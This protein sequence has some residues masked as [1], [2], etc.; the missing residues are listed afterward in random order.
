MARKIVDE[1]KVDILV[2][3]FLVNPSIKDISKQTGMSESTIYRL[4]ETDDF[5]T[6]LRDARKRSL[7][8]A[9]TYLQES[10]LGC[11]KVLVEIANN[12]KVAVGCRVNAAQAVIAQAGRWKKLYDDSERISDLEALVDKLLTEE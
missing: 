10:V 7:E 2:N 11:S 12:K 9:I 3:A 4:S 6:K 5:K 8:S 1:N